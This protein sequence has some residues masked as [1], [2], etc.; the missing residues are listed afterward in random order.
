MRKAKRTS[1]LSLLISLLMTAS[2]SLLPA[3]TAQAIT[4]SGQTTSGNTSQSKTT[5]SGKTTS[6]KTTTGKTT[7]STTGQSSTKEKNPII[8]KTEGS[9]SGPGVEEKATSSNARNYFGWQLDDVGWWYRINE[10]EYIKNGW[11]AI[12]G[13]LYCFNEKGYMVTGWVQIGENWYFLETDGHMVTGNYKIDK[14]LFH[15]DK[16]G[17][18][19]L[20]HYDYGDFPPQSS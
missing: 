13:K 15:F 20:D 11:A 14:T 7:Q 5:T 1:A 6:G 8:S 9:D 10:K 19:D 4:F 12:D 16:T 3:G 18:L 17:K 2:L